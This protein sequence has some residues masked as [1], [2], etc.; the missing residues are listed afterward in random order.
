MNEG[1]FFREGWFE[2]KFLHQKPLRGRVFY[3]FS[4]F[5]LHTILVGELDFSLE[6]L[7]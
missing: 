4:E 6:V 7:A 3:P 5:L 1:L 2:L